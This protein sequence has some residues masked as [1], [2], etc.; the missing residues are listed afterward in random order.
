MTDPTPSAPDPTGTALVP[1]AAAASASAEARATR[2]EPRSDPAERPSHSPRSALPV[3]TAAG[4]LLLA[5]GG[6]Y[7]WHLVS[8]LDRPEPII[9][10]T[11]ITALE[12]QVRALQQR[13]TALE[14]RPAAAAAPVSVPVSAPV[15]LRPIEGRIAALEQRPAM[16]AVADL[17]PLEARIVAAERA[18]RVQSA[19][20]ALEAGAPL[21]PLPGAGP[22]LARYATQAPPTLTALRASFPAAARAAQAASRPA[23]PA[24]D[25]VGRLWQGL[26]GLITIR[27]GDTLLLGSPAAAAL[28]AA[29]ARL[30][31]G[32]LAG[33]VA[34][35]D[36]LD[37]PA[38]A[39]M[40]AWREEAAGLAAAR[41]ALNVMARP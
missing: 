21:G 20:A 36:V 38:A 33:A 19:L 27:Q 5:A 8:E 16:T 11:R 22:A 23:E 37:P 17:A 1:P 14:Q 28:A 30:D 34:A 6:F 41:A 25:W 3:F 35:L 31:A 15:D 26:S 2:A 18:A 13:L 24:P 32:D 12:I 4:F 7:L 10:P 29:Q 39:A 40:T 9:D